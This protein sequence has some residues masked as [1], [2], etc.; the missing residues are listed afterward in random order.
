MGQG[1]F[2]NRRLGQRTLSACHDGDLLATHRWCV[3]KPTVGMQALQRVDTTC[4]LRPTGYGERIEPRSG[5][6]FAAANGSVTQA[7][8]VPVL[9]P[10]EDEPCETIVMPR[11]WRRRCVRHSRRSRFP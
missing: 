11:P 6:P 1:P 4:R 9:P 5:A 10:A 2:P 7:T 8:D 3:D